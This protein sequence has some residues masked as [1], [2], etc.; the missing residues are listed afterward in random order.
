MRVLVCR[1]IK[2]YTSQR[3][4]IIHSNTCSV[5]QRNKMVLDTRVLRE[6]ISVFN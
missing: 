3:V 6:T 4:S 5:S 1:R 2:K